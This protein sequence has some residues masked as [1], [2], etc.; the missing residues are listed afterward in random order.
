M[1][2]NPVKINPTF[3]TQI[4]R[5]V[6]QRQRVVAGAV[7]MLLLSGASHPDVAPTIAKSYGKLPLAFEP[8]RGQADNQV[9]FLAHGHGYNLFLCS[10]EAVLVLHKASTGDPVTEKAPLLRATTTAAQVPKSRRAEEV[11]LSMRLVGAVTKPEVFSQDLLPGRTHYYIGNNPARWHTDIPQFAKVYYHNVYP[12]IDL[13]YYGNRRLLEH[14]FIVAPGGDPQQIVLAFRGEQKLTVDGRGDLV[15]HVATA[16]IR[17]EKPLIYQ[18]IAGQRKVIEGAYALHGRHRA[19]FRLGAYDRARPLV[20]DPKIAYLSYLGGT[21]GDSGQGI[22]DRRDHLVGFA[23][24]DRERLQFLAIRL[25]PAVPQA[26]E[27]KHSLVPEQNP[28][29]LLELRIGQP[30]PFVEAVRDH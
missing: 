13:V 4:V 17:W 30:L 22:A 5:L 10:R 26:R 12:G 15:V 16:Q 14:D 20:I 25:P 19:E 29:R 23:R 6:R 3:K 18:E 8:N 1:K 28:H 2:T 24:D 7:L 27:R 9:Q 21:K 11:V